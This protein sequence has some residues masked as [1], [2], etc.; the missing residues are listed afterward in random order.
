M[1]LSRRTKGRV[2]STIRATDHHVNDKEPHL[3]VI[4][5]SSAEWSLELDR[6]TTE[7]GKERDV[8]IQKFIETTNLIYIGL[9]KLN[10]K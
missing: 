5:G 9:Y 3:V 8:D 4:R 6:K 2:T 10:N 7:Y 1:E